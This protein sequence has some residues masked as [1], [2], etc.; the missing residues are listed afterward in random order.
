MKKLLLF[1]LSVIT[2]QHVTAQ[3]VTNYYPKDLALR[4]KRSY[5]IRV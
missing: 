5:R 4:Y 2:L 1:V 3:N